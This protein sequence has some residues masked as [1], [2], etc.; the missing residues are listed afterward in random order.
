MKITK[1]LADNPVVYPGLI[2]HQ[3]KSKTFSGVDVFI[4]DCDKTVTGLCCSCI[5][6]AKRLTNEMS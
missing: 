1:S 3:P 4:L 5:S 6:N 2:Y